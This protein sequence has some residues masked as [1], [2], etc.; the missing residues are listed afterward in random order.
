MVE[1]PGRR[2]RLEVCDPARTLDGARQGRE[3]FGLESEVIPGARACPERRQRRV[4]SVVGGRVV[5]DL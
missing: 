5:E 3:V 1:R 4:A 2:G